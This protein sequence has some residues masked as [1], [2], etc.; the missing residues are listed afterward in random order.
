MHGV[1]HDG[2]VRDRCIQL[3]RQPCRIVGQILT[4]VSNLQIKQNRN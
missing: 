2:I 4:V 1:I 3:V